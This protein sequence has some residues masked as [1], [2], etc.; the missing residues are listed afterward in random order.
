MIGYK[1]P[2]GKAMMGF[3][4]PLGKSRIGSKVP[5]IMRPTMRNVEEALTRK[6]S[7]GLE[8]NVLKR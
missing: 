2:L 1:M 6:V 7:A 5:L 3:K 8:R 4:M